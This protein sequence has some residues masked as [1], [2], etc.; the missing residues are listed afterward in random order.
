[1][2]RVERGVLRRGVVVI[3]SLKERRDLHVRSGVAYDAAMW[4]HLRLTSLRL[5][6]RSRSRCRLPE[7]RGSMLRGAL[8]HELREIACFAEPKPCPQCPNRDR[9]AAG[10]LFETPNREDA[11]HRFDRPTGY[12]VT[13]SLADR[14]LF[15]VG[16]S[17]QFVFTLVGSERV[18]LPWVLGALARMGERGF[19]R[20]R[21]PFALARIWVE[22]PNSPAREL[23]LRN[24]SV[25]EAVEEI[26]GA[27]LSF[28]RPARDRAVI[29]FVTPTDLRRKDRPIERLDGETLISRGLRRLGGLLR[30]Y[31][32]WSPDAF[33]SAPLIEAAR[34]IECRDL[35]IQFCQFERFSARQQ[36]RHLLSGIVGA[37]ELRGISPSLWPYLVIGEKIHLGKGASFGMGMY[38]VEDT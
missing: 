34:R 35:G 37:I 16:D 10:A 20:E 36:T 29:R 25:G 1:M 13:P 15:D 12:I 33:D 18:W 4:S 5:E 32:R 7:H 38:L 31:C 6:Y 11:D 14:E 21:A 26:D 9:C 23:T 22:R 2:T 28:A 8:G 24:W 17:F 30:S 3:P 19:G 27:A